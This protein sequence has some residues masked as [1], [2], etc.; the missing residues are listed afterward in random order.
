MLELPG[1]LGLWA[2]EIK[3]GLT[4]RPGKGFHNAREDMKPTRSFIVY[5]GEEQRFFKIP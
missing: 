4:P 2:I 1:K 5:S 3:R